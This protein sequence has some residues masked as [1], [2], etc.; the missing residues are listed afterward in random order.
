MLPLGCEAAVLVLVL[1]LTQFGVLP[2]FHDSA[3]V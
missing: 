1:V 3:F 2:L